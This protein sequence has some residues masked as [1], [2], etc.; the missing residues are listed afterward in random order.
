LKNAT[1]YII[2]KLQKKW[3]EEYVPYDVIYDDY[4]NFVK[5]IGKGRYD[6]S[7]KDFSQKLGEILE[8]N[9][10]R[11]RRIKI[12]DWSTWST[13][14]EKKRIVCIKFPSL[15]ECKRIFFKK[16]GITGKL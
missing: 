4:Y 9:T 3:T 7:K 13:G 16:T 10:G 2:D 11:Q 15:K 14:G 1:S 12:R 5:K 6:T 8:I